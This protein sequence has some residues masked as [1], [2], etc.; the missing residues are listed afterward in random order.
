MIN[1]GQADFDENSSL[2]IPIIAFK[3]F[4]NKINSNKA[5]EKGALVKPIRGAVLVCIIF[6]LLTYDSV[7]CA[8][9]SN[10]YIIQNNNKTI[11]VNYELVT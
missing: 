8:T 7:S 3:K 10:S 11:L 2:P 9:I 5:F 1:I 6:Y 4:K